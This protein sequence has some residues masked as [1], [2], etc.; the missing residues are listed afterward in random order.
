MEKMNSNT[1][2]LL[3]C[4]LY[5][6]VPSLITAH[7]A[8]NQDDVYWRRRAQEAWINT[9]KSYN[10]NPEK[11][12]HAVNKQ[13]SALTK[14]F[15]NTTT[16]R[17]LRGKLNG[18]KG[19]C[20]ATNP[21]DACWRCDPNWADNRQKLAD[22][23]VGFGAKATG[24]KG[25]RI[26]V[27]SDPSDDNVVDP[28]PG[29]LRHAVIQKEPLW[30]IFDK[31]MLISLQQELIMQGDKTIDAR[32]HT[33]HVAF[34]AGITIQ[35]V[36]NV[37]IHGLRVH[38]IHQGSGGVVRDAE[39]HFGLRTMSDGDGISIF[40]S[41][42]VWI[43]HVSM[44][45]CKD[46]LIDAVEGSTGITISNGHFT[47]HNEVMLFGA[48]DSQ[49]KDALMQITVA[50]NHF[51]KRLVQRMPRCRWGYIHVV[52]NDYTHWEMYAIGGSQHPTII[53]QGNRFIAPDDNFKKEITKRDYADE[54]TWK[55]WTWRSEGDLFMNGAFFVPSGDPDFMSKH[56]E[57]YDGI[58]PADASQVTWMTR[59]AGAL[60]CREGRKC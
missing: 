14:S 20:K 56:H 25:G 13:A 3:L 58:A 42:D 28:K 50:F 57:L 9:Q 26:Y 59:F 2:F 32:G 35:F 11:V 30:I 46:G 6:T 41:S 47:D 22:C 16:R 21:I 4:I 51:G 18:G 15:W 17:E 40:G 38:D 29:T 43:D 39:D 36:K 49:S 55:N 33:V 1:F 53:S 27:V 24:G 48:S 19:E 10:P 37:I 5:V 12:I 23:V 52:N 8:T 60:N 45:N 44:W 7:R 34:G 31:N 54:S